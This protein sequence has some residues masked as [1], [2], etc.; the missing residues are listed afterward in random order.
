MIWPLATDAAASDFW[1]SAVPE[2]VAAIGTAIAAILGVLGFIGS[3]SNRKGIETI[4]Q[5]AN[6]SEG[7]GTSHNVRPEPNDVQLGPN[8]VHWLIEKRDRNYWVLRN[9]STDKSAVV[10]GFEDT[11]PNG[12]NAASTAAVLPATI[13]PMGVIPFVIDKSFV[14]PAVTVITVTW[15]EEGRGPQRVQLLV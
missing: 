14:S 8:P 10:I 13:P 5:A 7:I 3:R 1:G 11:T 2:W 9:G 4:K 12:D 6:S 15:E